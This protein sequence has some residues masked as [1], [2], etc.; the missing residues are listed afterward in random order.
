MEVNFRLSLDQSLEKLVQALKNWTCRSGSL[1]MLELEL[2]LVLE[3]FV[4]SV[5]ELSWVDAVRPLGPR[6]QEGP[7]AGS[8]FV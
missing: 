1:D 6:A 7:V 8:E 5:V 4:G 2:D 3:P